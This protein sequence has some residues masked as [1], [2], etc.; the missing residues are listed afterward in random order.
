VSFRVFPCVSVCCSC[1]AGV[2]QSVAG[3]GI[4]TLPL[5]AT[6]LQSVAANYSELQC[7]GLVCFALPLTSTHYNS[8]QHTA[9]TKLNC[10]IS[11]AQRS[12]RCRIQASIS[13]IDKIIG[14]FCKRAL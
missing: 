10:S 1:I 12:A 9:T 5:S 8:L 7:G 3:H 2:L 11:T 6:A 13:K 14:L 4:D